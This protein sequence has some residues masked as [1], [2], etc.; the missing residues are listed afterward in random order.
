MVEGATLAERIPPDGLPLDELLED[1]IP[2]TDAVGTAHQRGITH[3][4]LKPANVMI[5]HDGRVK[6]L[7]FGLAKQQLQDALGHETALP[8]ANL[9]GEGRIVGTV[10][11]M[12]PEQA[13]GKPVDQ[14]SDI[15]SLGIVLFEM[16]TGQRPFAGDSSVSV[17]SAVLKDTPPLVTDLRPHLPRDL[18]RMVKRCLAKDPEERYQTAKDLRND[19]KALKEDSDSGDLA[20]G[21]VSVSVP[22]I[23][24]HTGVVAPVAT[25]V[26]RTW[27]R[28]AAAAALLTGGAF[29]A[30]SASAP[31]PPRVTATRQITTDGIRERPARHGWYASV[32]R[33][34]PPSGHKRQGVSIR[35]GRSLRGRDGRARAVIANNHSRHRP[36]RHGAADNR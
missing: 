26:R 14:R 18:G 4:D 29:V 1:S 30:W 24:T 9:T 25:R 2:L 32:F 5:G 13:Q 8:T 21:S 36:E 16:A 22:A 19:L 12:A 20:K 35:A 10:A 33:C 31:A 27:P 23:S 3:R 17:L 11:Y 15:F 6:V 34:R 7:D 28:A